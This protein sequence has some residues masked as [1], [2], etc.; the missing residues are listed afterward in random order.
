M[1]LIRNVKFN[2]LSFIKRQQTILICP[3]D[4][5]LGHATRCVPI[6][7]ELLRLNFNVIIGADK[8]PLAF[9]QQEFPQ[10]KTLVIPGYEVT[11]DEKGSFFKLF[12]ESIRFNNF[13][14]KE[15]VFVDKIIEQ[16]KIDILI[17]DN[18]YGIWSKKVKSII[19]THQ[20]YPK[21]PL[22]SSIAHKK[23]ENLLGNFEECWIPDIA[24]QQNL[25]GDLSHLK[26]FKHPHRF[27]GLLSRFDKLLPEHVLREQK[28]RKAEFINENDSKIERGFEYDLIAILSGPEPQRSIFEKLLLQQIES[29][30]L[31]A[32]VVKGLPNCA[33]S[34]FC[35]TSK[36]YEMS[37]LKKQPPLN[38]KI[39]GQARND[40]KIITFNH[41][42]SEE[43]QQYINKSK[44]VVC[45]AGYSSIMDLITLNKQ[46]I[47]IPTPGQTEQEY[48]ANYHSQ[49]GNFYSQ[50]Q[51]KLDLK[52]ALVDVKEY[53]PKFKMS[54]ILKLDFLLKKL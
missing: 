30:K 41:L 35:E 1:I 52:K 28:L 39:P 45:R 23:I 15:H 42:Q 29:L 10:L 22:G 26:P 17:S 12:T 14:K 34:M 4:W 49:K 18:R 21:V 27:I 7:N 33:L 11:Y 46:A 54:A 25:S 6:I 24:T 38:T 44:M 48:L 19:I 20:L 51:D 37:N 8:N 5:G 31:K 40:E 2:Y 3:L 16:N 50:K 36:S 13:I 53:Q 32:V 43:L 9:L 47:L